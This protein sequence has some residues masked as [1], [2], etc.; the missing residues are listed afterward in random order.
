MLELNFLALKDLEEGD[1]LII[2]LTFWALKDLEED[3]FIIIYIYLFLLWDG[4]EKNT[5]D[6]RETHQHTQQQSNP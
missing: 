5:M 2:L 4:R 6:G 3:D 1:F